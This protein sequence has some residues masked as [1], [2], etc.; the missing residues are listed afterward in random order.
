MH[1]PLT[2]VLMLSALR[3]GLRRLQQHQQ[4]QQQQ[5]QQQESGSRSGSSPPSPPYV[6]SL[7]YRN[8]APL[9][10]DEEM[11]VCVRRRTARRE[12]AAELEWDVWI[13]GPE[14]GLA[15]KGS[16]VTTGIGLA[17]GDGR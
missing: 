12:G 3:A 15:A 6:K 1:G 7:D 13:E 8:L 17:G 16:A 10:V 5:Q 4:Q 14:G 11:R 2:L 9:Y